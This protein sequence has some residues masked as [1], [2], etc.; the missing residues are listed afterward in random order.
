MKIPASM[1]EIVRVGGWALRGAGFPFGVA[2]RGTRLLA[3]TEAVHGGAVRDVCA[4]EPIIAGTAS[5]KAIAH[6]RR[7]DHGWELDGGGRH[8][9]EAGPPLSDLAT[10]D[11]RLQGQGHAR[12]SHVAGFLFVTALADLL[13]RRRLTGLCIYRADQGSRLPST[14]AR[15]GWILFGRRG[16]RAVFATGAA[17]DPLT[18]DVAEILGETKFGPAVSGDLAN[19]ASPGEGYLAVMALGSGHATGDKLLAFL[20]Q[21]PVGPA[22][23]DYEAQVA[24]SYRNGVPM[25]PQD[26]QDLYDL[27]IRTWAPTSERSRS[28]AGY[29]KF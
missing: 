19:V 5:R 6:K 28:Q 3:F 17:T 12:I 26:L 8:L 22:L 4:H 14:V 7:S 24:A 11:A 29:G 10:C 18:R 27:E 2:E 1:S 16:N 21:S 25:E 15:S 9:I 23:R 13:A 20:D